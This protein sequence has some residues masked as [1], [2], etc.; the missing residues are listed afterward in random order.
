[1]GVIVVY[2]VTDRTTFKKVQSW[3]EE[4]EVNCDKMPVII[5]VGNKTDLAEKRQGK[6]LNIMPAF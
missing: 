2:D 1:L 4:V 5:L 3:L 6:V